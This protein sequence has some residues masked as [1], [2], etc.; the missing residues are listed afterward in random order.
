MLVR[1][2]ELLLDPGINHLLEHVERHGALSKDQ[3]MIG[4]NVEIR[5]KLR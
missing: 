4:A 1:F 2:G 3:I 5:T